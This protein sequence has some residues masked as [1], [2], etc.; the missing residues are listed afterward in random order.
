MAFNATVRREWRD[1]PRGGVR[2]WFPMGFLPRVKGRPWMVAFQGNEF[3]SYHNVI[4]PAVRGGLRLVRGA[5][6][7]RVLHRRGTATA[8]E[9]LE[10][11]SE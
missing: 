10:G 11:E 2:R 8:V 7:L 3:D 6:V 1:V 9:Y 4:A 5:H